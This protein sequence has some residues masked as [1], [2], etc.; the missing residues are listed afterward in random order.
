MSATPNGLPHARVWTLTIVSTAAFMLM[1]DLTVVNVALPH[2]R[3]ALRADFSDLQW[4]LDAYALTLAVF[5]LTGGSLADRLGRK[6][7]FQTGFVVFTLAS[8]ACGLA[9]DVTALNIARAA[10]GLGAALLFAVGPAL[11][12]HEYRGKDRGLAF[13]VFGAVSGLAIAFGPLIG[14]AL[15]DLLSWRW[16]FLV[17][18]PIGVAVVLVGAWR[19]KESRDP[20]PHGVDWAGLAVFSAALTLVV[21]G[22]M[23][24]QAEGW[25]S[26]L[27]LGMFT[28]GIVLLAVF[29][30]LELRR[31]AAAMLDL[32]LFR[33][34]TFNG[35]SLTAFIANATVL[36][37]IFL[38]GSYMENVLGHSPWET[39]VRFLPLTLTLFAAAAATGPLTVSLP[40]RL[41]VGTALA[42]IAVGLFLMGRVTVEDEWTALL[43]SMIVS[44]V[45]LGM[46]NPPRA[47][48]CIGV[49]EPAKAGMASGI[50]ETFQQVGVAV[51]I[52]G[53]GALFQNRVVGAFTHSDAG[54][55]LGPHAAEAGRAAAAGGGRELTATLPPALADQVTAAAR[56]AF[57]HGLNDVL[58]ACGVLAS[59]GAVIGFVFIRSTD[60][61]SSALGDASALDTPRTMAASGDR[62]A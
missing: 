35:I 16:I 11:I 22:F 52:A 34:P 36:S 55:Q 24:G 10:Q 12:G 33:I 60:L 8:L 29:V 19:L 42:C 28:A 45:G 46:F 13:G 15:T 50:G 20:Q 2:M 6:R 23:R 41:L 3:T 47:S 30:P 44:G 9:P 59:V 58:F 18:V 21:L 40:P 37:A 32:S 53:F 43:P 61:H 31:G 7:V 25:T 62:P 27:I 38:Q 39:G 5:L 56:A 51:G 26:P 4:V 17:N 48:L 54:R 14:G 49:T 1:L 57:V